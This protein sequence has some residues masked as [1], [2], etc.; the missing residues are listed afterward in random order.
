[1]V[2]HPGERHCLSSS[3][4]RRKER[5]GT[6][7]PW[8][9]GP[10]TGNPGLGGDQETEIYRPPTC[11]ERKTNILLLPWE[12]T[13]YGPPSGRRRLFLESSLWQEEGDR[14]VL[15]PDRRKDGKTPSQKRKNTEKQPTR[16]FSRQL[17]PSPLASKA[18]PSPSGRLRRP[19][20]L[21]R[22]L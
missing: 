1:M 8:D 9:G 7:I 14:F 22:W 20:R 13:L 15:P 17:R 5:N 11:Q 12:E 18:T 4:G 21:R 19:S 2:L 16:R 6:Y 10:R 3:H